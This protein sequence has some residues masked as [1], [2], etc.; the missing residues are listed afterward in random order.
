MIPE[1]GWE[2]SADKKGAITEKRL[3]IINDHIDD[4]LRSLATK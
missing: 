1:P 2:F 3:V 4:L